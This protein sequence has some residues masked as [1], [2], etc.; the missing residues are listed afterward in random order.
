M[1]HEVMK[2]YEVEAET[3]EEAMTKVADM[4]MMGKQW[5]LLRGVLVRVSSWPMAGD[6]NKSQEQEIF[7]R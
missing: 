3:K 5:L 6:V 2:I 7:R 4:E 1:L